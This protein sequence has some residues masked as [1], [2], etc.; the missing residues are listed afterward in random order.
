LFEC[1]RHEGAFDCHSFCR[2]CEGE[3]EYE[4]MLDKTITKRE[5]LVA[6]QLYLDCERA[7]Y[8]YSPNP[9][10]VVWLT[11]EEADE[12]FGEDTPANAIY[13]LED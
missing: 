2:M 6:D 12:M 9:P 1:P 11:V 7:E 13:N 8:F 3:Q 10:G 5:E 4:L